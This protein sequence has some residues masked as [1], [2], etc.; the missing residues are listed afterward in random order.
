MSSSQMITLK[1]LSS[2]QIT[3]NFKKNII[4]FVVTFG[5]IIWLDDG[6]Y[7][8][9]PPDDNAAFQ[10]NKIFPENVTHSC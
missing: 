4:V 9:I 8:I 5:V 3:L 6:N 10:K 7:V 2:S 1:N